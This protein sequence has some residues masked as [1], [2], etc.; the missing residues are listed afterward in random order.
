[1]KEN[2]L[3]VK[4]D[5][6]A[7]QSKGEVLHQGIAARAFERRFQLADYVLV[8]GASLENG[9]L[10]IDLVREVPEAKKP[11]TIA[12]STNG[13]SPKVIENKAA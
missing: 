8:K 2:A 5:K 3:T 9:L 12:I 1:V 11:R 10:H 7:N 6:Q 13:A 4:G